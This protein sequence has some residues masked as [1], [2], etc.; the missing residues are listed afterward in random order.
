MYVQAAAVVVDKAKFPELL[1]KAI[2]PRSGCADH[3]C[4]AIL[5]DSGKYSF[6]SAFLAIMSEQ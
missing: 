4:Q 6:G 5:A 3:L 2:D 1:H